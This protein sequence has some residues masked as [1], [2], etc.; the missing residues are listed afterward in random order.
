MPDILGAQRQGLGLQQQRAALQQQRQGIQRQTAQDVSQR[1][2]LTLNALTSGAQV[3][4]NIT[5]QQGKLDFLQQQRA[6]FE[7]AGFPT[8]GVDDALQLA[9]QGNFEQLEIETDRLIGL[10][11]QLSARAQ[12]SALRAFEGLTTGLS[13]DDVG[14]ARR[15]QL[16]LDPRAVGT[17]KITTAITPG[18]TEKVAES[19]EIIKQ[20]EKFAEMTGTSRAKTID[21]G[22]TRIESIDKSLRNIDRAISAIDE[23]ASTGVI[24]SRFFPSIRTAS[25]KLD[26]AQKEMGLDVISGVTFG[27]L[28]KGELDLS[29][30]LALPTGL[31][32]G[33]LKE[34]L[35][36]K[37]IAQQKLRAYFEEQINFLD[38]G[39]TIAGFLRSKRRDLGAGQAEGAQEAQQQDQATQ[40]FSG[41]I[42]QVVTEEDI[43]KTLQETPGLTRDELFKRLKIR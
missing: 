17:G 7:R 34:W 30:N 9:S 19:S 31:E 6:Q 23:G 10:G 2:E 11:Q 21:K 15:I 43:A 42:S 8:Q 22:F 35:Q 14:R 26:Q 24:E 20:R 27:A 33:P 16:G 1:D 25:I 41:T 4:K 29:L 28:S 18:L 12:P 3:L 32:P 37:K 36:A 13:E 38:Q 40:L 39:G 5:S